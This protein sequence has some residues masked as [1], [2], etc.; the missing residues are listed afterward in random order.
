MPPTP[1]FT[2]YGLPHVTVL[3]C[4]V[5]LPLIFAI[6]ARRA[7]PPGSKALPKSTHCPS[8]WFAWLFAGILLLQKLGVLIFSLI[9]YP[10]PWTNYLPLHLCDLVVFL[11]AFALITRQQWAYEL[12]YFW[13]L[14]GTAQG[15]FTPDLNFGFPHPY[16]FFFFVSHGVIVASALYLTWGFRM[17]PHALSIL[18]AWGGI[19]GYAAVVYMINL[20]L[21]T[22]FGYLNAR[23]TNPSL[24]DH[25]WDPP[26]HIA[27]MALVALV[28]FALLYLPFLVKDLLRAKAPEAS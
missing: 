21:G 13:G 11:A 8:N 22:N 26:A 5:L 15:L 1:E 23:P 3:I 17:R 16:F 24:L 12:T 28:F 25:F 14:A 4:T 19:L 2:P 18:V 9:Y 27:Q 7:M 20:L 6:I 10:Q